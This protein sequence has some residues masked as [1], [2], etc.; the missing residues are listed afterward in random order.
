MAIVAV[1]LCPLAGTNALAALGLPYTEQGGMLAAKLA[2]FAYASLIAGSLAAAD[3]VARNRSLLA[4]E[5]VAA[6]FCIVAVSLLN[7]ALHGTDSAAIV[8]VNNVL[9]AIACAYAMHNITAQRRRFLLVIVIILVSINAILTLVE[10]CVGFHFI[11]PPN[12]EVGDRSEFRPIGLFDHPLSGAAYTYLGLACATSK[13]GRIGWA[14]AIPMTLALAAYGARLALVITL[15]SLAARCG[16]YGLN[17]LRQRV[18]YQRHALGFIFWAVLVSG[19]GLISAHSGVFERVQVL[20]LWDA[21]A[22]ARLAPLSWLASLSLEDAI[23]G[24]DRTTL[25]S[26]GDAETL[27]SGA[28]AVENFWIFMLL[29]LGISGFVPFVLGMALMLDWCRRTM[30]SYG[31]FFLMM[32]VIL[33]SGFN[34]LGAKSGLLVF[35]VGVTTAL[36]ERFKTRRGVEWLSRHS[37]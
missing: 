5:I 6:G 27:R 3:D 28:T 8:L 18:L 9:P 22:A 17:L 23:F 4:P 16:A 37:G 7:F 32:F 12:V 11:S 30:G 29:L 35:F 1:V 21:S 2:P 20:G 10:F 34:S 13:C 25:I 31:N 26:L 14:I 33:I 24:I 36:G 19:V 15:I